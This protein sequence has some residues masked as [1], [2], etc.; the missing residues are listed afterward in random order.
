LFLFLLEAAQDGSGNLA[1]HLD[2]P[3]PG[4]GEG[5]RR[6]GRAGGAEQ[7][8]E[9]IGKEVG[10]QGGFLE[11][12]G[13]ARSDEAGPVLEFGLPGARLL[14]E[15]ERPYLLAQDFRVGKRFGFDSHLPQHR[16]S[17]VSKKPSVFL[18][19]K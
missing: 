12:V 5:V 18:T 11:L 4:K 7:A 2:V 17:G 6:F 10:E 15:G 1:V 16:V 9:D 14:R 8:V 13:A 3:F 19:E